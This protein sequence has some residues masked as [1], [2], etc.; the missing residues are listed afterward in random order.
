MTATPQ[1]PV[2]PVPAGPAPDGPPRLAVIGGGQLARMMAQAAVGL[3]VEIRLL[4]EG[5]DVSAAQVVRD[6][7][8]GDYRDEATVREAVAGCTVVTFDHEHVPTP[9]L[10]RLD[11]DGV[12]CRPGPAAL[13]HAQ[14]K[15]VM[16]ERLTALGVP[17]PRP[18]HRRGSAAA[19]AARAGAAGVRGPPR[20]GRDPTR[21]GSGPR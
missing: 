14:D 16:R 18:V 9:I 10:E 20:P 2:P 1:T 12:A 21:T 15:G 5:A 6:T 17:G 11:A 8:V 4:A 7:L 13:V 19:E 3:G